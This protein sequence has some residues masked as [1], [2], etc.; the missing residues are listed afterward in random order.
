LATKKRE[1]NLKRRGAEFGRGSEGEY[2]K[3]TR[4]GDEEK[5]CR[6]QSSFPTHRRREEFFV[7]MKITG[8]RKLGRGRGA[9]IVTQ[10]TIVA[11]KE[12]TV[13]RKKRNKSQA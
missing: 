3:L 9:E 5:E 11:E 6:S 1:K 7:Q 12:I 10:E 8:K 4:L 2:F 13:R